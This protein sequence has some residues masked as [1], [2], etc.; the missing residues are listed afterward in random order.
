MSK[1]RELKLI[2][3][4]QSGLWII[5]IRIDIIKLFMK[6]YSEN[7]KKLYHFKLGSFT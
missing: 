6:L 2:E 4:F 7:D 1:N 5:K 3:R